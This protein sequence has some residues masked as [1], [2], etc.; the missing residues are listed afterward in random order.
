MPGLSSTIVFNSAGEQPLNL[1]T[2]MPA[3]EWQPAPQIRVAALWKSA[4]T[5]QLEATL[6]FEATLEPAPEVDSSPAESCGTRKS[7]ETSAGNEDRR[8][9]RRSNLLPPEPSQRGV[10]RSTRRAG[11]ARSPAPLKDPALRTHPRRVR[12]PRPDWRILLS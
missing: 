10:P 1:S 3:T 5:D 8:N 9:V 12:N 7:L 2:Q 11:P 4:P 6:E